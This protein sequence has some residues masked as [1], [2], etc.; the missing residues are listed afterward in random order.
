MFLYDD[1]ELKKYEFICFFI[2]LVNIIFKIFLLFIGNE[3]CFFY[4]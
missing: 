1:Y 2:Y 3:Y 4:C